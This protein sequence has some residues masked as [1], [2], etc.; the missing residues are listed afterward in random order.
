MDIKVERDNII[1]GS[2]NNNK[3]TSRTHLHATNND[4]TFLFITNSSG[5]EPDFL[6][7]FVILYLY[8][9]LILFCFCF[10]LCRFKK[11]MKIAF[12]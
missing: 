1:D 9:F 4:L 2:E 5:N 12:F 11:H 8:G 3:N 10:I 6:T 7:T